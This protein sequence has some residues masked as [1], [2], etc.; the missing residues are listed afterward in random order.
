M[1]R[2]FS[3]LSSS[4]ILASVSFPS[5]FAIPADRMFFP[6]VE[7]CR[8][9]YTRRNCRLCTT[10]NVFLCP[11]RIYTWRYPV[12]HNSSNSQCHRPYSCAYTSPMPLSPHNDPRVFSYL[13]NADRV[14]QGISTKLLAVASAGC[15]PNSPLTYGA[16]SAI[17]PSSPCV[18]LYIVHPFTI[19]VNKV[20]IINR[21]LCNGWLRH[22]SSQA[23][24]R[25]CGQSVGTSSR[26]F[27]SVST[28]AS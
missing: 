14:S 13:R 18:S 27:P 23:A 2:P 15:L 28:T 12:R 25:R 26:L 1:H 17:E 19:E 3:L 8:H 16:V 6:N 20:V 7:S 22:L 11:R 10:A 21:F 4:K 24:H 5:T 9:K